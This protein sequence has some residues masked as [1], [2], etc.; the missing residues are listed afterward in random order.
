MD[1][2]TYM[3]W[4]EWVCKGNRN[5]YDDIREGAGFVYWSYWDNAADRRP[6]ELTEDDILR[7]EDD[8]NADIIHDGAMCA[9]ADWEYAN[10]T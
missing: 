1:N 7:M 8:P 4:Y 5:P 6:C 3:A 9:V 2:E 10:R